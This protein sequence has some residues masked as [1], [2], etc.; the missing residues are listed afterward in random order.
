MLLLDGD[1]VPAVAKQTDLSPL[2]D[3]YDTCAASALFSIFTCPNG[4]SLVL[5]ERP[6]MDSGEA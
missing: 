1:S 4:Q 5:T 6:I 3:T 2:A